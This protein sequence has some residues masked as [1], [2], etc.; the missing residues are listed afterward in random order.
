MVHACTQL[1]KCCGVTPSK[2]VRRPIA[3]SA[4]AVF[5][6]L[7]GSYPSLCLSALLPARLYCDCDAY[8]SFLYHYNM[9]GEDVWDLLYQTYLTCYTSLP[10]FA[11]HI[12][13]GWFSFLSLRGGMEVMPEDALL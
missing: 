1:L 7:S 12:C 13:Y 3:A 10:L 5:L 9:T 11:F 8:L 4:F 2:I 6:S